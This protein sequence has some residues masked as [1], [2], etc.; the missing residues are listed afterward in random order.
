MMD[1]RQKGT[2]FATGH[3]HALKPIFHSLLL[4]AVQHMNRKQTL[5]CN[6]DNTIKKQLIMLF[7][8]SKGD[9]E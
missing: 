4:S 5:D 6:F 3:K 7:T 9:T 2:D 8:I 1:R